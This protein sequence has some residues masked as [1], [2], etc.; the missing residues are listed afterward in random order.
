[1][2]GIAGSRYAKKKPADVVEDVGEVQKKKSKK[3]RRKFL[4]NSNNYKRKIKFQRKFR[5]PNKNPM[6]S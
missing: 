6:K 3:K 4:K 2:A 5:T 1:M